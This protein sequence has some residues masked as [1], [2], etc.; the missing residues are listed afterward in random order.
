ML[1]F[2]HG[3]YI[4]L[5][6]MRVCAPEAEFVAAARLQDYRLCFPRWSKVRD[7][8]LASIEPAKGEIA[9]GALYEVTPRDLSRL[10]LVEGFV[11]DRDPKLNAARRIAVRVERPDGLTVDAETHVAVP[12]ADPGRPSLSYL[13]V[14][15]RAATALEF[16]HDYI[17]KLRAAERAPLAA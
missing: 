17:A 10:D 2:A 7:S 11:A 13:L 16:P 1:Y 15:A 6:Q 8:A 5:P 4:D 3:S 14:L 9:W 12:M